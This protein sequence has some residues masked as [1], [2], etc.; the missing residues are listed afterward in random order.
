MTIVKSDAMLQH[1]KWIAWVVEH[2]PKQLPGRDKPVNLMP[3]TTTLVMVFAA[4]TV[5][6]FT[7]IEI[8]R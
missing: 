1:E 3:E 8:M 5:V 2:N 4:L 6:A 7:V